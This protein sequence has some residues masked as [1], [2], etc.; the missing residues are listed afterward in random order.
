MV[1]RN[2]D[3][4]YLYVWIAVVP[5]RTIRV[6]T[7]KVAERSDISAFW[8]FFWPAGCSFPIELIAEAIGTIFENPNTKA[9]PGINCLVA[10]GTFQFGIYSVKA[11]VLVSLKAVESSPHFKTIIYRPYSLYIWRLVLEKPTILAA[12]ACNCQSLAQ[13]AIR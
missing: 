1:V 8:S 3:Q 9:N 10:K 13:V 4:S 12:R 11:Q 2:D 5:G 6:V 7:V